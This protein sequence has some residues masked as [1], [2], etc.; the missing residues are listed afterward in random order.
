MF[1]IILAVFAIVYLCNTI[2]ALREYIRFIKCEYKLRAYIIKYESDK[3]GAIND[4]AYHP[5]E[6]KKLLKYRPVI[7]YYIDNPLLHKNVG[8]YDNFNASKILYDYFSDNADFKR[9]E[10]YK[11]FNPAK[12]ISIIFSFPYNLLKKIGFNVESVNKI[13]INVIGSS[14]ESAILYL[15]QDKCTK[16]I[17][18]LK[19]ILDYLVNH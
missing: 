16:L 2:C 5:N 11:S 18:Q 6:L 1:Q 9:Y 7:Q 17:S 13:F 8:A 19:L 4:D 14:I 3:P 10:M 12:T 15:L